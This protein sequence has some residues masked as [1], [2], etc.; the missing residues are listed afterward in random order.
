MSKILKTLWR[1]KWWVLFNIS[2]IIVIF[3]YYDI[4]LIGM[5]INI[6]I[7]GIIIS[8]IKPNL[9]GHLNFLDNESIYI[10]TKLLICSAVGSILV[11]Y[12]LYKW[13]KKPIRYDETE[14]DF[15]IRQRDAILR[16]LL[17]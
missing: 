16:K 14:E 11:L 17:K 15:K 12:S 8:F 3:F 5:F 9:K 7:L 2:V 13:R 1:D 4:F 10:F 6:I